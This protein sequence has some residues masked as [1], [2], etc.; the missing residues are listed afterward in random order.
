MTQ[1]DDHTLVSM[2]AGGDADAFS[3]LVERHY[4]TIYKFAYKWYGTRENAE[5]IAQE[6]CAALPGK[7]DGF[8]GDAAFTTWLYRI[9][10]NAAKDYYRKT[11]RT[12]L[13]ETAFTEGF[14]AA[15]DDPSA[16]DALIA[17][18]HYAVIHQLPEPIRDAVLLV[19]G[20]EMSHK[21]A[22]LVL[23]C[24]ETTISWRI[25]KARSLLKSLIENGK[26]ANAG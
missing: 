7:L 18:E 22:A 16:E 5:D 12:A 26:Q 4:M 25:F 21:E 19:F 20:E 3:R 9:V 2:A 14:D 23:G 13:R 24:A 11:N 8:R 6:V 1:E 10:I 15:S 17:A